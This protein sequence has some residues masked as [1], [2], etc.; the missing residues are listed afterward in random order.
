ML[1]F[2]KEN[3]SFVFFPSGLSPFSAPPLLPR[4][5]LPPPSSPAPIGVSLG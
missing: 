3:G 1:L 5:F 2:M 4:Q